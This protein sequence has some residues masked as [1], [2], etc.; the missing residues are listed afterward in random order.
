MWF[1]FAIL[2]ALLWGMADLFYKKGSAPKDPY[3][4]F[5]IVIMVGLIMGTH[6]TCYMLWNHLS[7]SWSDAVKYAPVSAMYI[8]SMTLGYVGLRYIALSIASPVQNSSGAITTILLAI[9]FTHSLASIEIVSI[10]LILSGILILALLEK[11]YENQEMRQ[12]QVTVDAKYKMGFLALLFPISYAVI[13]G[14]GTFLDGVYLDEMELISEDMAL[15][16][17]E[18]TFLLCA[19]IIWIFLKIK[20]VPFN[21]LKEGTRA[22]AGLFETAGQF[23]YVF[24]MASNAIISAP[25]IATYSIFSMLLARIFLKEKLTKAQY[26]VILAVLIGIAL[27]GIADEL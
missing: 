1:F 20:K 24:A 15:L 26:T 19:V 16:A 25:I 22:A 3:S 18:Y 14:L 8:I 4:H 11:K 7:F 10:I 5:K 21:P 9:F 17:Y 6:A 23:F 13:D 12:N 27:L 2:T